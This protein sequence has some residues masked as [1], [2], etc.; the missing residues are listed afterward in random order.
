LVAATKDNKASL[1]V[2]T[3]SKALEEKLAGPALNRP[4][5]I[6]APRE[7]GPDMLVI[8]GVIPPAAMYS[9]APISVCAE[10]NGKVV[11]TYLIHPN[12]DV[13]EDKQRAPNGTNPTNEFQF[14][15]KPH[16]YAYVKDYRD[17]INADGGPA[18]APTAVVAANV[19]AAKP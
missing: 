5:S 2:A 4:Q 8:T 16:A 18:T 10:Q 6:T 9:T 14:A 7:V 12:G 11:A 19:S 13:K 17:A 1:R 3:F 15:C